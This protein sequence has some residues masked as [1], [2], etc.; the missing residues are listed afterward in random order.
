MTFT[1]TSP[2]ALAAAGALL[3]LAAGIGPAAATGNSVTVAV[4]G[5]IADG[6][7]P[8]T[9]A[10]AHVEM[11]TQIAVWTCQS[12]TVPASPVSEVQS[13]AS[14]GDVLQ[15]RGLL[16]QGC[17]WM[18]GT[19]STALSSPAAFRVTGPATSGSSD[20]VHGRIEDFVISGGVSICNFTVSGSVRA[21]LNESTQKLTI[22]ESGRSGAFKVSRVSGCLGLVQVGQAMDLRTTLQL[23]S[24][25]GAVNISGS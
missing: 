5:S 21:S 12:G 15:L 1:R 18:G 3:A 24:P 23:T 14:V 22:D 6:S 9:A 8:F 25:D 4:G 10:T 13:G 2:R 7:H 11:E 16:F 17:S 20:V 19:M